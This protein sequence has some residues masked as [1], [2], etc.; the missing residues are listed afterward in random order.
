ML[1]LDLKKVKNIIYR[2]YSYIIYTVSPST[3]INLVDVN[4]EYRKP[5][6]RFSWGIKRRG[7]VF[8]P[9]SFST[10]QNDRIHDN[11]MGH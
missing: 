9:I 11:V 10:V 2:C 7:L 4:S 8:I 5:R 6:T 1:V 3:S